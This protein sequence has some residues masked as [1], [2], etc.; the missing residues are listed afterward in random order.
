MWVPRLLKPMLKQSWAV[1][2]FTLKVVVRYF[3]CVKVTNSV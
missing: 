1:A 3:R 2:R